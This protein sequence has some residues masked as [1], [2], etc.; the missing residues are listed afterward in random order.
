M[1]MKKDLRDKWVADLRS[2][3]YAQVTGTLV[4]RPIES[5]P[6]M[7]QGFCCLGVLCVSAGY[8]PQWHHPENPKGFFRIKPQ[9]YDAGRRVYDELSSGD[10]GLGSK[11]IKHCIDMN[12]SG[13]SFEKIADWIEGNIAVEE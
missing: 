1:P 6:Q 9:P 4:Q 12:D 13:T 3:E 5:A 2:G 7:T 8:E 10:F 11:D